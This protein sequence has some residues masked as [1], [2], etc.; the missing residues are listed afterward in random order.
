MKIINLNRIKNGAGIS[1]RKTT[2]KRYLRFD[3][4]DIWIDGGKFI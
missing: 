2:V 4:V 3:V 1:K